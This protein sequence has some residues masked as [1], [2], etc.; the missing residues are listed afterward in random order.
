M[1]EIVNQYLTE[2]RNLLFLQ[3]QLWKQEQSWA[4]EK[5][6][7]MDQYEKWTKEIGP[8]PVSKRLSPI[9]S[10]TFGQISRECLEKMLTF[11]YKTE[12]LYLGNIQHELDFYIQFGTSFEETDELRKKRNLQ[13]LENEQRK[14]LKHN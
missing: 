11:T 10:G 7:L 1:A 5:K 3:K 6:L 9:T 2:Q 8:L 4:Q 14:L 13:P 12:I